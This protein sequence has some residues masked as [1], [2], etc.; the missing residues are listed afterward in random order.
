MS[1]DPKYGR[2][3]DHCG[4]TIVKATRIYKGSEYCP[5][6]YKA[7]FI[8]HTCEICGRVARVH[9]NES[10]PYR[11]SS[12]LRAARTCFRCEK[13][14][15]I[16]GKLIGEKAICP[17]CAPYFRNPERCTSCGKMSTRLSKPLFVGWENPICESCRSHITHATCVICGRYRPIAAHDENEKPRCKSCLPGQESNHQCPNCGS[18]VPGNGQGRCGPC[19][20]RSAIKI[21]ANL[22]SAK[23]EQPWVRSLW[24]AFVQSQ[25]KH[26][27]T[28]SVTRRRISNSAGYFGLIDQRFNLPEQINAYSLA[29]RIDSKTHRKYL[30]ASRFVV[31]HLNLSDFPKARAEAIEWAR[32]DAIL[33]SHEPEPFYPLLET[34]VDQLSKG[35]VRPKTLRMYLSAAAVFCTGNGLNSDGPWEQ[36]QLETHLLD[37]PGQRAN[38]FRF[39]SHCRSQYGWSVFMPP[40]SIMLPPTAQVRGLK[41]ALLQVRGRPIDTLSLRQTYSILSKAVGLPVSAFKAAKLETSE[42]TDWSAIRLPDDTVIKEDHLLY[43]YALHW[44]T[45]QSKPPGKR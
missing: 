6:C 16:A 17:S 42:S 35:V 7:T 26:A 22:I 15:P 3:C 38:L 31:A 40:G 44:A 20:T 1:A 19:I 25:D 12:C 4:R 39:V 18:V 27:D 24:E 14:T 21:D 10:E 43:Q 30:L 37:H 2:Y 13:P 34:F 5:T 29:T 8:K 33:A 28:S 45:K 36:D 23:F 41:N 11:C 32:I 9:K